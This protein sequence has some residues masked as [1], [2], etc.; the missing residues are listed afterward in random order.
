MNNILL[1][2]KTKEEFEIYYVQFCDRILK[3]VIRLS[4][5]T[6]VEGKRI[7]EED[8]SEMAG[9]GFET[10]NRYWFTILGDDAKS[11]G[12]LWLSVRGEGEKTTPYLSDLYIEPSFRGKGIGKQVLSLLDIELK[13]RGLKNNIRVHI[14]GDF[15]ESAI[16]LF[17]SSGYFVHGI[18]MEKKN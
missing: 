7:L 10:A 12:S 5:V 11:I 4:G 2:P 13:S 17:K 3:D 6:E 1:R 14:I 16:R 18:L 9:D 8:L 15:N